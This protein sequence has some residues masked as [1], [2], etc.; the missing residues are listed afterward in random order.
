ELT[1][2]LRQVLWQFKAPI[3]FAFA[4]GSGVFP[5]RGYA[6]TPTTKPMVDYIF[7]VS[8]AQH[9]HS[10]NLTDH[11]DHYSFLRR[12]GSGTISHVQERYGA[13]VYFNPYVTVNGIAIKYGVVNLDTLCEDLDDWR[14]LYLAGRMQKPIKVL[15][16]HPQVQLA[17]QRT[18]NAALRAALL[19]LPQTFTERQLF[20]TIASLSYLGDPRMSVGGEN[21]KKVENI[22]SAQQQHFR[23]LYGPL[24]ADLPNIQYMGTEHSGQDMAGLTQDLNPQ[25]RG[26]MVRR[27]PKTFQAKLYNAYRHKLGEQHAIHIQTSEKEGV[28]STFGSPFDVAIAA[29]STLNAEVMKAISATV[30][31]PSTVQTI[32]GILTAGPFKSWN[33]VAEKL[34]K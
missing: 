1:Q 6:K 26:N 15:R 20:T 33:Y 21:P 27:L 7:G 10:L 4:Y 12:L 25:T 19:L 29:S 30:A 11:A 13:G 22:V 32:K 8:H 2:Q 34:K 24:M 3:R 14:T 18:L 9:F 28:P 31:W 23:S 16:D 17:Y 5:Q